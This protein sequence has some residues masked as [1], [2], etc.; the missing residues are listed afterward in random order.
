MLLL[1]RRL[2]TICKNLKIKEAIWFSRLIL[3]RLMTMLIGTSCRKLL[4]ILVFP[5][6][7]VSYIMFCVISSSLALIWNDNRM[8]NFSLTRFWDKW[9]A[10]PFFFALCMENLAMLITKNSGEHGLISYKK[11]NQGPSI[12]HNYFFWRWYFIICKSSF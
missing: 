3:R 9:P 11:F 12:S 5:G 8:E 10:F 4:W 6:R 2:F 1:L 7:I